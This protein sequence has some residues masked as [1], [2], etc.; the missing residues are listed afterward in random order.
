MRLVCQGRR[1]AFELLYDRYFGK[2]V[3]YACRMT[4]SLQLAEDIVQ[5]VFIKIIERPERFDADKKFSTW[6]YTVTTNACRNVLRNAENRQ[7]IAAEQG[8]TADI[9]LQPRQGI[10]HQLLQGRIRQLYEQ[11]N[12]KE[13]HI[14]VLRFE[15]E[16]TIKEIAAVAQIPEGSVKSGIFYLLKKLAH[17]LKE[18]THE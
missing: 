14:F 3:R 17:Q 18:F 10:D 15:Q 7:R 4:N 12:E 16:L 1:S 13:Q 8:K 2:L 5:D 9:H 6:I 11:L